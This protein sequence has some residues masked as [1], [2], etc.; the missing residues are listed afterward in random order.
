MLT[1]NTAI[2]ASKRLLVSQFIPVILGEIGIGK[3]SRVLKELGDYLLALLGVKEVERIVFPCNYLSREDFVINALN[4]GKLTSFITD[5][6]PRYSGK[7]KAF[8]IVFDDYTKSSKEIDAIITSL[9]EF[10]GVTGTDYKLPFHTYFAFTGNRLSDRS[11]DRKLPQHLINRTGLFECLFGDEDRKAW[12]TWAFQNNIHEFVIA[13]LNHFTDQF[14]CEEADHNG[15]KRTPRQWEKVSKVFSSLSDEEKRSPLVSTLA[16][17]FVG[18]GSA[19]AFAGF[20]KLVNQLPDISKILAKDPSKKA[21]SEIQIL[22]LITQSLVNRCET[23]EDIEASI[24]FFSDTCGA[25]EFTNTFIRD[26]LTKKPEL[27][28]TVAITRFR[29]ENKDFVI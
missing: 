26:L 17:A 3:T 11:N 22:H 28:K 21:V 7:D 4:K 29:T 5:L 18:E 14:T 9:I 10:G 12:K 15:V 2:E 13:F 20:V 1:L 25:R 24:H 8:L 19:R 6:L 16:S 27:V 23:E